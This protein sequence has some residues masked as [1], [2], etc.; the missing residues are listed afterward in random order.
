[1]ATSSVVPVVRRLRDLD[2][3]RRL[4]D[5][6][7]VLLGRLGM[8]KMVFVPPPRIPQP[9]DLHV[10]RT[11]VHPPDDHSLVRREPDLEE[12]R[13]RDSACHLRRL[14]W[15]G[16]R[17]RRS[18]TATA[19]PHLPQPRLD[20]CR[21]IGRGLGLRDRALAHDL[22]LLAREIGLGLTKAL[23]ENDGDLQEV[24]LLLGAVP[25]HRHGTLD[26]L[27]DDPREV[28]PSSANPRVLRR[29]RRRRRRPRRD[30]RTPRHGGSHRHRGRPR[31]HLTVRHHVT[32]RGE[33][34]GPDAVE[35]E[36]AGDCAGRLENAAD[37][38]APC[39]SNGLDGSGDLCRRD[40][41][42][43]SRTPRPLPALPASAPTLP[44]TDDLR[45]HHQ[46]PFSRI[47]FRG[48]PLITSRGQ[49]G[50]GL[51]TISSRKSLPGTS[52][53]VWYGRA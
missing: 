5:L 35:R 18:A 37:S 15:L 23:G 34:N 27:Y 47:P 32:W 16:G 28:H 6:R 30:R 21:L 9:P 4:L 40:P 50:K 2:L 25:H 22:D 8:R 49:R 3:R 1:M 20:R 17:H 39:T 44:A 12:V 53:R 7:D 19:E 48:G 51:R 36:L 43:L 29:D 42:D 14:P 52:E 41:H 24:L 31:R 11:V 26:E 38:T 10:A 13:L 46:P 33:P 45:E